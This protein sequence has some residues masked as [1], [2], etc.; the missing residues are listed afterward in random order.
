MFGLHVVRDESNARDTSR[1]QSSGTGRRCRRWRSS[2]A[3]VAFGTTIRWR[4]R[5][6]AERGIG[7]RYEDQ[8]RSRGDCDR[9]R[10]FYTESRNMSG[11]TSTRRPLSVME[12]WGI[13]R[14]GHL[15]ACVPRCLWDVSGRRNANLAFSRDRFRRLSCIGDLDLGV[16]DHHPPVP[17]ANTSPEP[18][19]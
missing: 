6:D 11:D 14:S 2:C 15:F 13:D 10:T 8:S 5:E 3:E 1:M 12:A 19:R 16:S 9:S 4:T 17:S 7:G 18:E